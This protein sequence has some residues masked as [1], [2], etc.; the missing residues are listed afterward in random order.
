MIF[1][2]WMTWHYST[3]TGHSKTNFTRTQ[4]SIIFATKTKNHKFNRNEIAQPYLNPT[5]KRI[6]ERLKNGSNGRTPYDVFHFNLVKNV[7]KDKTEHP[8]QIPVPL[9]RIFIKASSNPGDTVLDP[10]AGSFST[11]AAAK[12][13]GR[14]SI[15][16]DINPKY[17]EIGKK[18]LAKIKP[19][20]EFV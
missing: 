16:I 5:D 8:C 4:H 17:V 15:G 7:S 13:L 6:Q 2:R 1:K 9:L 3:N 11:N 12:E 20:S 14:N 19:L 10:F 18:R